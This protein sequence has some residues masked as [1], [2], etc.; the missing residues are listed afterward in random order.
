MTPW[1]PTRRR[2]GLDLTPLIDVVFTL[3]LVVVLTARFGPSAMDV[4]LPRA[5]GPSA[6]PAEAVEVQVTATVVLVGGRST[7]EVAQAVVDLGG[8]DQGVLVGADS[9]VDYQ[10]VFSVLKAL[11]DAGVERVS[12]AY[13]HEP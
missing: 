7:S 9:G 3:L 12:L 1:R 6:P 2:P 11:A 10:R 4:D 5:G 8:R 13:D